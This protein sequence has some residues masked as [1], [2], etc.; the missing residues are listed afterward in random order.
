MIKAN[1]QATNLV[2]EVKYISKE[3]ALK[4]YKDLNKSDPLLLEAVTANMLPASIEVSAK[5]PADLKP[6]ADLLKTQPDIEDVRF[7]EDIVSRLA[8]WTRSMRLHRFFPSRLSPGHHFYYYS[9]DH[10]HQSGQPP[11]RDHP[12]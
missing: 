4:L 10:R 2:S 1:L 5:N 11:G 8:V 6:I 12:L 9:L 7:A 3:E